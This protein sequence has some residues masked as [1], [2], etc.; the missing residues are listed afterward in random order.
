MSFPR[1]PSSPDV[2]SILSTQRSTY[3]NPLL[4]IPLTWAPVPVRKCREHPEREILA[5]AHIIFWQ[6]PGWC[7]NGF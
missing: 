7:A 2:R 4:L 5:S 6:A 3:F 1:K